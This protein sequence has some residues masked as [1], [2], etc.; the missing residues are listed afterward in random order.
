VLMFCIFIVHD[1]EY[2]ILQMK[3]YFVH[4][5]IL[6]LRAINMEYFKA[7]NMSTVLGY[8]FYFHCVL[9]GSVAVSGV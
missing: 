5:F 6:L 4:L 3:Q 7:L 8:L 1:I 2:R 9:Y